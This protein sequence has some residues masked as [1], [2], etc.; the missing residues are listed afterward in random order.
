MLEPD[1]MLH[2]NDMELSTDSTEALIVEADP[3]SD[4]LKT[5]P[6]KHV[7]AEKG[8]LLPG[9]VGY[10]KSENGKG[11]KNKISPM[12]TIDQRESVNNATLT[13]GVRVKPVAVTLP[14]VQHSKD[15]LKSLMASTSRRMTSGGEQ[16]SVAAAGPSAAG[17]ASRR[18]NVR[19]WSTGARNSVPTSSAG[20]CRLMS[21]CRR[22]MSLDRGRAW[23]R[24]CCLRQILTRLQLTHQ[25]V[26]Q[27]TM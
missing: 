21:Q 5:T 4:I 17:S 16:S 25:G 13:G 3:S 22:L 27:S 8:N 23:L 26:F 14:G 15:E 11:K 24:R 20:E 10:R 1:V 18:P 9:H 7:D 6:I 19:S 2:W 12:S